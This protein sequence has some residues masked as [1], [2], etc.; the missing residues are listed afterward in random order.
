MRTAVLVYRDNNDGISSFSAY[1]SNFGETLSGSQ[2]LFA[3]ILFMFS[4]TLACDMEMF[5]MQEV[6]RLKRILLLCQLFANS[7]KVFVKGLRFLVIRCFN[8]PI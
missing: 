8:C 6:T 5:I 4:A 1:L 3:F 2:A 7:R